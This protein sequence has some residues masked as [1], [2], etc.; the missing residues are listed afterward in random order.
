MRRFEEQ[1]VAM[2]TIRTSACAASSAIAAIAWT[3]SLAKDAA[4]AALS[5]SA[6]SAQSR[7][8]SLENFSIE[9]Y[10]RLEGISRVTFSASGR[11]LITERQKP[12]AQ[13]E[14][15]S[16]NMLGLTDREEVYLQ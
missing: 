13:I 7:A 12:L 11:H 9:H 5:A 6:A 14:D 8:E 15:S 16:L 1:T 10:L 3:P 4:S 2:P